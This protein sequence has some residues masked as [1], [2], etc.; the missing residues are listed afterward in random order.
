MGRGIR[1]WILQRDLDGALAPNQCLCEE[2]PSMRKGSVLG[3]G[4]GSPQREE[5]RQGFGE[6]GRLG[7]CCAGR[8]E[9][10]SLRRCPT[11]FLLTRA[12]LLP[13]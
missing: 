9:L 7:A 8:L 3:R 13:L 6:S 2:D 1:L 11:D 4:L 10:G 12:F 5:M